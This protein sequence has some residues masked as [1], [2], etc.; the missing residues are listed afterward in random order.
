MLQTF[1]KTVEIGVKSR[2][3]VTMERVS[4]PVSAPLEQPV[5]APAQAVKLT[6][7]VEGVMGNGVR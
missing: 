2:L 3:N 1:Q 6:D 7:V 4:V 5:I